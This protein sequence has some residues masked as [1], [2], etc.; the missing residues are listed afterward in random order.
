MGT[1]AGCAYIALILIIGHS[2]LKHRREGWWVGL[3]LAIFLGSIFLW[4]FILNWLF[5]L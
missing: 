5:G 4:P 3:A 2:A 1:L